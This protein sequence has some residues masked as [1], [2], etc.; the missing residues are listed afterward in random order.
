VAWDLYRG[1]EPYRLAWSLPAGSGQ[2][3]T[4]KGRSI[5][6]AAVDPGGRFVA[7]SES[8][9]LRIGSARDLVRVFRTADASEAVRFYLPQHT[10]SQ[11]MFF[12]GGR[13]GYSD[14]A[15]THI[16]KIAE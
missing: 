9:T 10:R 2:V 6:S 14:A 16:L 1:T 7:V 4:N 12:A 11:L 15:G 3:R 13:F 5:T 8:T